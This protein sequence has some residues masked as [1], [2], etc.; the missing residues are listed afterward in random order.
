MGDSGSRLRAFL[1]EL[2]RRRVFRVG[3][4]YAVAT[5]AI[6]QVAEI[7]LPA[8]RLPDWSLTLVVALVI[9]GFPFAMVLAWAFDITAKGV[10]RTEPLPDET[11]PFRSQSRA[12]ALI[13]VVAVSV[14]TIAAGWYVLPRL[15]G[16]WGEDPTASTGSDSRTRIVVLPFVNLGSPVD[17]YF[18]D[19]ITEEITAQLAGIQGL[20]VIA[21]T[22]AVQYKNTDKTVAEIGDELDVEYVLEGTIRWETLPDATSRVRVTP[23]LIRVEDATHVWAH[24]YEEPMESVFEVQSEIAERV[25]DELGVTLRESE[26]LA[27]QTEPTQ[28][29]DA[30]QFYLLGNQYLQSASEAGSEQALEMFGRALEL[31]PGFE[32]AQKKL[33]EA[34]ANLYWGRFK[35]LIGVEELDY[36][37]A[38]AELWVESF[39][40]DTAAYFLAKAILLGRAEQH[41]AAQA[42]FDSARV[43]LEPQIQT[44]PGDARRHAQLGLAYA[45]LGLRNQAIEEGRR[46][47]ELLPVAE[48]AYSGA[49]LADNLA[50]IYT[51]IGENAQA[52]EEI[53]SILSVESPV[54]IPWL[55]VDPTWDPL[56]DDPDFRSLLEES[57]S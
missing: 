25:V 27:L 7:V 20:G 12:P 18:A 13:A 41:A 26:R 2:Q 55:R 3:V 45:G 5:F 56:R 6:L 29:V 36:E 17:K 23:Q 44:R 9:L 4:V 14:L 30:Y 28:N 15:P 33:A 31:D 39:G 11:A 43:V 52:I 38:A 49:A 35:L 34:Y 47:K 42:L 22:T 51:I 57:G 32:L 1:A 54:S 37:G 16:W 24:I 46:A 19:G 40:S 21:R 48:D 10:V 53:G 50:H 8:L